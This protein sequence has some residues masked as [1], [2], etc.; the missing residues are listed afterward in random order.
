[1]FCLI[2]FSE[3]NKGNNFISATDI[4]CLSLKNLRNMTVESILYFNYRSSN[5][6]D[7]NETNVILFV[8]QNIFR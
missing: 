3:S 1:M 5:F 7:E 6:K 4:C 2:F 8:L